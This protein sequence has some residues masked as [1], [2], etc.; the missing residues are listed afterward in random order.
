MN[1]HQPQHAAASADQ[2][3]P[4]VGLGQA[5][6]EPWPPQSLPELP[7]HLPQ[8]QPDP[9]PTAQQPQAALNPTPQA[10]PNP[11]PTAQQPSYA[12]PPLVSS[13]FAKSQQHRQPTTHMLPVQQ[14][15]PASTATPAASPAQPHTD[16]QP[17]QQP[18]QLMGSPP[19]TGT[20]FSQQQQF[21]ASPA[22]SAA[23]PTGFKQSAAQIGSLSDL[24]QL[25]S[26]P[27]SVSSRGGP[28][29]SQLP[30][31]LPS[32]GTPSPSPSPYQRSAS[33]SILPNH[34]SDQPQQHPTSQSPGSSHN[35]P[36]SRSVGSRSYGQVPDVLGATRN[37]A[38]LPQRSSANTPSARR[39][40]PTNLH[41]L[42]QPMG[43]GH[44]AKVRCCGFERD[45][46]GCSLIKLN[47]Q[48]SC[49]KR[50][51]SPGTS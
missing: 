51:D 40:P 13:P 49:L 19:N 28:S 11:A 23:N 35:T 9:V 2:S 22:S 5:H 10:T 24:V 16:V 25:G 1:T 12:P 3:T 34:P 37:A 33:H 36:P 7:P 15:S 46:C 20:Q 21:T 27:S 50:I 42:L 41:E 47:E 44:Y 31:P 29:S 14:Q 45:A 4:H 6:A 43:M 8:A 17:Q 26:K 30:L 39:G 38:A 32:Q 18:K 48:W